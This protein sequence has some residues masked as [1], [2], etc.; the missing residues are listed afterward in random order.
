M[1][2]ELL[3]WTFFLMKTTVEISIIFVFAYAENDPKVQLLSWD[4]V[5]ESQFVKYWKQFR[6]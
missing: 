3:V 5:W 1:P 6:F 4:V 2:I